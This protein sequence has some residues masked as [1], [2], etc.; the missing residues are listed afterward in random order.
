MQLVLDYL[1]QNQKRFLEELYEYLRLPSV[2]A[3]PQ[4]KQDLHAC[5]EWLASHCRSIGL[6]ARLCSTKNHPIV[7][8]KTPRIKSKVKRPHFMLYGHYDVQPPEPLEL[9][10]TPPFEPR[11]EGR[12]LFARGSTD[13]KGQNFAHLK[14]VEAY[15]KT[16]D[17][18]AVRSYLRHRRRG[19]S[20][21]RKPLRFLKVQSQ[22]TA[23]RCHCHYLIP[24]CP[25]SNI[26][27]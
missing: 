12:T 23:L 19:R 11:L 1:K 8:A 27:P 13:N 9:W 7:V 26:R 18:V 6:E 5:A 2:S 10:K 25:A 16:N 21:Q 17:A 24:A 14:A 20:R 3:Q 4:H 15:L 22:G